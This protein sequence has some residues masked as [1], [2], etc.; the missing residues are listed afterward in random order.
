M[1]TTMSRILVLP[2][3]CASVVSDA[4]FLPVS[5]SISA[6]VIRQRTRIARDSRRL[7]LKMPA[8]AS[9]STAPWLRRGRC[10]ASSASAVLLQHLSPTDVPIY[11]LATCEPDFPDR[12]PVLEPGAL[13]TSCTT[14]FR[15]LVSAP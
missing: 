1:R 8:E 7:S 9:T 15:Y 3:T 5:P 13:S 2:A 11:V 14:E 6:S 12:C 4:F 10:S